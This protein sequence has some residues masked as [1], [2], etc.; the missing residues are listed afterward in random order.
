MTC[1]YIGDGLD[2][3]SVCV[4]GVE[5]LAADETP[6]DRD[7]VRAADA[8][9]NAERHADLA[10]VRQRHGRRHT[11]ALSAVLRRPTADQS[12][13]ASDAPPRHASAAGYAATQ[14]LAGRLCS[15]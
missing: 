8:V 5:E 12:A 11:D 3:P 13:S 7:R 4:V 6:A 15:E 2:H 9:D 10:A 14:R 1:Q